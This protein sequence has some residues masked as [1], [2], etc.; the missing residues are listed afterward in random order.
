[1]IM[2]LTLVLVAMLLIGIGA[3]AT[4]LHLDRV[5]LW[6]MADESALAG[7]GAFDQD[8]FY[9]QGAAIDPGVVSVS[10]ESVRLAVREYLAKTGERGTLEGVHVA[11]AHSPDGQTAVVVLEAESRPRMLG[12]LRATFGGAGGVD[13]SVESSARSWDARR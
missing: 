1:M 11:V 3:V 5:R 10:N 4:D 13:L 2:G 6:D 8:E 9:G 7:A 12:W